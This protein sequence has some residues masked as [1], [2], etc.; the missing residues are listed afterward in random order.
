MPWLAG[1]KT[2]GVLELHR[3]QLWGMSLWEGTTRAQHGTARHD[4]CHGPAACVPR[5]PTTEQLTAREPAKGPA[6]PRCQCY[7][8]EIQKQS[9]CFSYQKKNKNKLYPVQNYPVFN[10]VYCPIL[11]LER[12]QYNCNISLSNKMSTSTK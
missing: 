8:S 3:K 6:C 11:A 7:L 4:P 12:S 2:K 1:V 10:K 9:G 5:T